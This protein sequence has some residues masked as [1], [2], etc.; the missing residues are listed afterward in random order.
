MVKHYWSWDW[1]NFYGSLGGSLVLVLISSFVV[2]AA[3]AADR[4]LRRGEDRGYDKGDEGIGW[5]NDGIRDMEERLGKKGG[6]PWKIL[7]AW[8]NTRLGSELKKGRRKAIEEFARCTIDKPLCFDF[9]NWAELLG[10]GRMAPAEMID[11]TLYISHARLFDLEV[12][13]L[14]LA[15]VSVNSNLMV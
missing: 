9:W 5:L 2:L 8:G 7:A 14:L 13:N 12:F 6:L 15:F 3:I 11:L 4:F 1:M 10:R